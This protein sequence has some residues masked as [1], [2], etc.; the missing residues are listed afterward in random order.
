MCRCMLVHFGAQPNMLHII[1]D[2]YFIYRY[3]HFIRVIAYHRV[4]PENV[5]VARDRTSHLYRSDQFGK[6]I[7]FIGFLHNKHCYYH[8]TICMHL[9]VC[10]FCAF[11]VS[12]VWS[13]IFAMILLK[14]VRPL[15]IDMS[16]LLRRISIFGTNT[17]S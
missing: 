4:Q 6:L 10:C 13:V 2:I 1:T 11:Y 17:S 7:Y 9:C 3:I 14:S 8:T 12:C 16:Y 5:R 15:K